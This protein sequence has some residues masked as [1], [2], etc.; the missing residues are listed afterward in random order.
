[1]TRPGAGQKLTTPRFTALVNLGVNAHYDFSRRFGIF[2]G[3][4]IKNIGFIEKFNDGDSTVKRRVYAVGVPLGIKIGDLRNRNFAFLGGGIDVPFHYREKRYESRG[5]KRKIGEW[6]SDRTALLMPYVFAGHSFN[7]GLTIKA[8]YYPFNFLNTDYG[9]TRPFDGYQVNL[10]F[11]SFGVDIHYRQGRIQ[12]R[13][14]Q[15]KKK[16]SSDIL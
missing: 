15:R 4:G 16:R 13:D 11:I 8:Q 3:I 6:F 14:Y 2:T 10:L 9:D 7:P 1:M 12:E 5:D